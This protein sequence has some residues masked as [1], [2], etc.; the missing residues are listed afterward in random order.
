MVFVYK[1]DKYKVLIIRNIC[2]NLPRCLLREAVM[3][4]IKK[5][6][7]V[8][9]LFLG[10]MVKA[11]ELKVVGFHADLSMVD[12]VR[13]PKEDLNGERCGL[14]KLGLVLPDAVF[15]GDIISAEYK[16]GEWW[17][18]MAKGSNWL[19]IKSKT[20]IPL[21]Y[22]FEGIQ[23]NVTYIM[24][25]LIVNAPNGYEESGGLSFTVNDVKFK[26]I[27]VEGGTFSMGA[28]KEQKPWALWDE[29]PVRTVTLDH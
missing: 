26:M 20:C 8:S 9:L 15:E 16:E 21:R 25:V 3:N 12:A 14:I 23:S 2:L 6:L 1:M 10:L 27:A 19:T 13:F 4:I 29:E 28:T 11:Q 17:I 22:E 5:L 18:Y 7:L 24:N